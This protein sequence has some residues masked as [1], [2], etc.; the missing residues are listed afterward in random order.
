MKN[1][2]LL[3]IIFI[4]IF[5]GVYLITSLENNSESKPDKK[6]LSPKPYIKLKETKINLGVIHQHDSLSYQLYFY[7][8]GGQ[9]LL[10][11]KVRTTCGCTV[12]SYE[13][14]PVMPGDSGIVFLKLDTERPGKFY[15]KKVAVYSNATNSYDTSIN[16]SRVM[17]VINWIVE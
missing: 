3:L 5:I 1:R 11:T 16:S 12:A 7:N 14:T 8:K 13:K 6:L 15:N 17:A 2:T 4:V 10:L 9:P